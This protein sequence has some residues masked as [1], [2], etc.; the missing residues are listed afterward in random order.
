MDRVSLVAGA[1]IALLGGLLAL[2]QA[3]AL[4]LDLGWA[5]AAFAAVAG[6]ILLASGLDD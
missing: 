6:V 2:D 5:G 4:S 1:G 3:G